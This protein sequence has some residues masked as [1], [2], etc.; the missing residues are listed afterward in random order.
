MEKEVALALLQHFLEKRGVSPLKDLAGLI[1]L[2]KA[3]GYFKDPESMFEIEEWRNY[4]DCLWDL[5]IDDDK[6]AKK[7]MKSWREVINCLK[8]YKVEKQMAAAASNRLEKTDSTAG[9][10]TAGGD[11]F[12]PPASGIPVP[13]VR[14][15]SNQPPPPPHTEKEV[16][17]S[18]PSQDQVLDGAQ[19][20]NLEEEFIELEGKATRGQLKDKTFSK[21][22]NSPPHSQ[23]VRV[24]WDKILREAMEQK[25]FDAVTQINCQAYPVIYTIDNAGVMTGEHHTLDW[26]ILNQ[27]R[28]TVNDSGLHGEPTRQMLNYIWGSGILCPEDIKNIMR[29]ILKQSQ[30]LLW[31]AHWQ[32]L[33]E[34]SV[35]AS[36]DRLAGVTVEQLMGS[37]PFASIEMQMQTG[38]D[39]LLESMKLAREALQKVRTTPATPSYMS[40]KQGRDES[41]ASFVDR[42]TDAINRADIADFMKGPLLRQCVLENC[43]TY[44]KGILVTLPLDASVETMLERMSRVPVG[45]QALLVEALKEVGDNLV[46]TQQQAFAAL[47]PLKTSDERPSKK[48]PRKDFICFR[49]GRPGHTRRQCRERHLWC[50]NCQMDTAS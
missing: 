10:F 38:P 11:Y 16:C 29:L 12:S 26:K 49:C 15:P 4:G 30:Q 32:R 46:K 9:R 28:S 36:R 7:L 40:V 50:K 21:P 34:L 19:N 33:C 17:P 5:V 47:A 13:V 1:T 14:Q 45:P 43:N 39:V 41:F 24:D 3:K 18:A 35:H 37:G 25:D 20:D 2:G 44:T 48:P 22:V 31:Q 27:L 42:V 8:R 23:L 6:V